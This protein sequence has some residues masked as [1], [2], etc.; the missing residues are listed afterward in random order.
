MTQLGIDPDGAAPLWAETPRL[1]VY[2]AGPLFSLAERRFNVE[3]NTLV[4]NIGFDTYFPQEDAGLISNMVESGMDVH[5]ARDAIFRRNRDNIGTS[6]ILIFILDGRV[7]DEGA[8]IEAGIGYALGKE[9]IGL[10]TDFRACEPGGNNLMIDGV[11]DYR[12]AENLEQLCRMLGDARRSILLQRAAPPVAVPLNGR[13]RPY[14]AVVGSIGTGKSTLVR[15]LGG[16]PGWETID[17]P[18]DEN[19][20]LKGVYQNLEGLALRVQAFYLGG[21]TRQ[22]MRALEIHG[23]AVQDRCLYED[24][25]VFAATYHQMGAFDGTD[26]QTLQTLYRALAELLP[27][28]D[29]LVYVHAPLEVQLE[30]IRQRGRAFEEAIAPDFLARLTANYESWIDRQGWA[31]VLRI[32][33]SAADYGLDPQAQRSVIAKV[34]RALEE[35]ASYAPGRLFARVAADVG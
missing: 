21:R 22:H 29:L 35:N 3:L 28:P 19:P 5:E 32:D 13:A 18:V 10:K 31:P 27:R 24:T 26:L 34:D 1:R 20:Y 33:S 25:E 11:L 23:P 6:D 2:L 17:E 7:P 9:C 12:I 8:S 16:R 4:K 14:V 15:L 30:R